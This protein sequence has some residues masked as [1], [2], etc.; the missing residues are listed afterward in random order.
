MFGEQLRV[1]PVI[2]LLY[3]IYAQHSLNFILVSM[4]WRRFPNLSTGLQILNLFGSHLLSLG[5]NLLN[6]ATGGIKIDTA[7]GA[8]SSCCDIQ[9]P[10]LFDYDLLLSEYPSRLNVA[11]LFRSELLTIE[12]L[13]VF[14]NFQNPNYTMVIVELMQKVL[15]EEYQII[16]QSVV[17]CFSDSLFNIFD[18]NSIKISIRSIIIFLVCIQKPETPTPT[19]ELGVNN[20]Q[21]AMDQKMNDNHSRI[22]QISQ[23][24]IFAMLASKYHTS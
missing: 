12:W 9:S 1:N 16:M 10:V 2:I 6:N 13:S 20:F 4:I 15:Q 8:G 17:C 14:F 3:I 11:Q 5:I 19:P 22:S 7:V 23:V 24:K 21:A 18:F